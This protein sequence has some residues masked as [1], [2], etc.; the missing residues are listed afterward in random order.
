MLDVQRFLSS[1]FKYWQAKVF[2]WQRCLA[3]GTI[4]SA[5]GLVGPVSLYCDRV[6][7]QVW[8]A[9]SISVWQHVQLSEQVR[10]CLKSQSKVAIQSEQG[11]HWWSVS[12]FEGTQRLKQTSAVDRGGRERGVGGGEGGRLFKIG[13]H[14]SAVAADE[15]VCVRQFESSDE[16]E[17]N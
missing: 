1:I 2:Q 9:P 12:Y 7:W 6:R 5:L 3:A 13:S 16:V 10:L 4:E 8:S 17:V 14:S 11:D 15:S